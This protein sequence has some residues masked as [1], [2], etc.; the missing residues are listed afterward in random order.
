MQ[1]IT[2]HPGED[3]IEA[4]QKLKALKADYL[5]LWLNLF[6]NIADLPA[7]FHF[8][9][10]TKRWS[11]EMAGTGGTIASMISLYNMWGAK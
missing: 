2:S 1:N 5:K 4:K 11:A 10:Y 7:I 9:G 3:Q 8:M 6:R